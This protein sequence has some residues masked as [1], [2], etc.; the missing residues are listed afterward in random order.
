[1]NTTDLGQLAGWESRRKYLDR[2]RRLRSNLVHF[3]SYRNDRF[4]LQAHDARKRRELPA[5]VNIFRLSQT[6][7]NLRWSCAP[8]NVAQ[9]RMTRSALAGV[10]V[11]LV[12]ALLGRHAVRESVPEP[13]TARAE[14]AEPEPPRR[15][16]SVFHST[17]LPAE[18]PASQPEELAVTNAG[19]LDRQA[20]ALDDALPENAKK[21]LR[22]WRTNVDASVETEL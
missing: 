7:D 13:S 20:F 9:K 21:L 11:L 8:I 4:A 1:L 16:Q 5:T 18:T 15:A 6:R 10:A 12:L 3:S 2:R 19:T 14:P 22:D 17:E